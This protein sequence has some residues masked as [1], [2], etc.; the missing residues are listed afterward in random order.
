[1]KDHDYH[2]RKAINTNERQH[3]S[4]YRRLRNRTQLTG[5]VETKDMWKA[6]NE[7]LCKNKS[8]ASGTNGGVL[9]AKKF[10]LFFSTIATKLY[11]IFISA[12]TMSRILLPRILNDFL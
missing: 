5:K 11:Q 10:S 12:T 9:T 1:M 8:Q 4:N 6:I 2:H 3:W 7:P